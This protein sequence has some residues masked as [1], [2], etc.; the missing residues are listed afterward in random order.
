MNLQR[1][2]K[3]KVV[4]EGGHSELIAFKG[5]TWTLKPLGVELPALLSP[6]QMHLYG[7]M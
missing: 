4:W 6:F 2:K 5:F 7:F 3:E 1:R